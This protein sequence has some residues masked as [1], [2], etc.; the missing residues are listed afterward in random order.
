LTQDQ[1]GFFIPALFQRPTQA[2]KKRKRFDL[3]IVLP[4]KQ[5]KNEPTPPYPDLKPPTNSVETKEY[6]RKLAANTKW[7]ME[8][9]EMSRLKN[10]DAIRKEEALA[11]QE[12]M[13][14]DAYKRVFGKKQ[15]SPISPTT[16]KDAQT[17]ETTL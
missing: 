15:L 9:Q 13:K 14:T 1:D 11:M 10:T 7:K 12:F 16:L 3:K 2:A 5:Q 17:E 6:F 4:E 8:Q